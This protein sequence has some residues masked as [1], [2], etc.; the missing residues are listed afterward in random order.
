MANYFKVVKGFTIAPGQ[1]LSYTWSWQDIPG[2]GPNKGPVIF[3][4]DP[5]SGQSAEVRLVLFDVAK[6]RNAPSHPNGTEVFYSWS[7]RN[8]SSITAMFDVENVWGQR[9]STDPW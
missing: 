6:C 3:Y 4:A 8:D 9:N 2:V 5:R 1:T 7:V